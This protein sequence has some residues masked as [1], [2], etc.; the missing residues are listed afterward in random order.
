[1]PRRG[2][3]ARLYLRERGGRP[4]MWVILD[5]G[6]EISTG[7]CKNDIG[8]AEEALVGYISKKHRPNFGNGH[9]TQVLIADALAEYGE[10]HAPTTR[11][12]DL[13]GGAI[14]KLLGFF[15]GRTVAT[16][17]SKLCGEYVQWRIAQTDAR[18]S[19]GGKLIKS[20]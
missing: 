5:H 17:T 19:R 18:A 6:R 8:T 9:P 12:A 16:I 15:G 7:A 10:F 4:A 1:M 20:S 3:G 11:R 13:V 14:V 2:K